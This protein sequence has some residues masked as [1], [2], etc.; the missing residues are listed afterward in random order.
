M[1]GMALEALHFGFPHL[2]YGLPAPRLVKMSGTFSGT[3]EVVASLAVF[4]YYEILLCSRHNKHTH[5]HKALLDCITIRTGQRFIKVL[6]ILHNRKGITM[7]S[8]NI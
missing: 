4:F 2:R 3:R 7:V 5:T 8:S 6:I 1:A